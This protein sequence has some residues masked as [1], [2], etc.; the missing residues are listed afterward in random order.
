MGPAICK[1]DTF[2]FAAPGSSRVRMW[3]APANIVSMSRAMGS[4]VLT[5]N[6]IL[7]LTN[8]TAPRLGQFL[9]DSQQGLGIPGEA[10]EAVD[11]QRVCIPEE[12]QRNFKL[13]A[14]HIFVDALSAN[15]RCDSTPSSQRSVFCSTALTRP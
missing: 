10:V 13:R 8:L 11:N 7:F 2:F 3:Q 1:R 5:P 15:T 6:V 12:F 9:D 4:P 14:L